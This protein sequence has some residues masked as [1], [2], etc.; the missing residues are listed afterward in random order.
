MVTQSVES[1]RQPRLLISV[2]EAAAVLSLSHRKVRG[3]VY[4]GELRSIKVGS[5]RL[6]AVHDL[7]EFVSSLRERQSQSRPT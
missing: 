7:E 5:R 1:N 3:L 4:S 6:I 2:S